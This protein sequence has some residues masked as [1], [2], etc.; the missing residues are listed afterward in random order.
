MFML[1]VFVF[2]SIIVRLMFVAMFCMSYLLFCVLCVFVLF[3]YLSAYIHSFLCICVHVYWPLPHVYWPLPHVYWPLPHVYWPLPHVYHYH[4]FRKN[5]A[6][7][8]VP[9]LRPL[10]LLI[11]ELVEWYWQGKTDVLG[12]KPI[13]LSLCSPQIPH[14]LARK[15][16]VRRNKM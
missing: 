14:G 5:I 9:R 7:W 4:H 1:T 3:V 6:F 16:E 8:T 10:V 11:R 12:E 15:P 2:M 13:P